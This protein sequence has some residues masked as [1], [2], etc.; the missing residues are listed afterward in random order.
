M[1][2]L[3]KVL[4]INQVLELQSA[5]LHLLSHWDQAIAQYTEYIIVL[6]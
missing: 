4:K 6:G 3:G 2:K 1:A 5:T